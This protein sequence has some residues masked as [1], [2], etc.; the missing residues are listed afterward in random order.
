MLYD[1]NCV[2]FVNKSVED[3]EQG[4]DIVKMETG[5]WFV[6]DEKCAARIF[7]RE[8]GGKFDALVFATGKSG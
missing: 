8:F 2:A 3:G 4:V 7:F 6:E 5:S 1:E